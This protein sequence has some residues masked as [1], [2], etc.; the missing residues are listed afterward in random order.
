[1][2]TIVFGIGAASLVTGGILWF[3]SHRQDTA[4]LQITPQASASFGGVSL[5]GKF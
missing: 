5:R 1:V 4:G 3:T 2:A